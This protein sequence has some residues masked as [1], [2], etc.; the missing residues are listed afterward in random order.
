MK[1]NLLFLACF[2]AALMGSSLSVKAQAPAA[3]TPPTAGGLGTKP[4]LNKTGLNKTELRKLIENTQWACGKD[5]NG[6]I[7]FLRGG[8]MTGIGRRFYTV[9]A[10]DILRIYEKDPAK[11]RKAV[12][13][14][15]RVHVAAMVAEFDVEGTTELGEKDAPMRYIGPVKGKVV[16]PPKGGK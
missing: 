14:Q 2:A 3:A 4:G 10:P 11:D 12:F 8:Q 13:L 9:E 5:D 16:S 6:Q 7:L 1:I 15:F